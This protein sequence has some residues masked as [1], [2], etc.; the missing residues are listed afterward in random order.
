MHVQTT[1]VEFTQEEIEIIGDALCATIKD[2]LVDSAEKNLNIDDYIQEERALLY[3][4]T[5]AGYQLWVNADNRCDIP[6]GYH[7]IDVDR[8]IEVEKARVLVTT[9][10]PK[11]KKK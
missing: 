2:R 9:K 5:G 11:K 7:T 3:D 10:T 4:L 1:T 8:W 6:K